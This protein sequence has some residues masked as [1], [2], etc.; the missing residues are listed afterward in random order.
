M[1][2]AGQDFGLNITNVKVGLAGDCVY[3]I[4]DYGAFNMTTKSFN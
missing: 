1:F 4:A 2:T 3:V